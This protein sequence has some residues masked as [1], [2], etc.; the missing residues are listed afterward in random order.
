[1][2]AIP[3]S[4]AT[5]LLA[6]G[7]AGGEVPTKV[8]AVA[9]VM[10]RT[11]GMVQVANA[12][13]YAAKAVAS[14]VEEDEP[15]AGARLRDIS[16]AFATGVSTMIVGRALTTPAA[17][18]AH[19]KNRDALRFAASAANGA[20]ILSDNSSLLRGSAL[21]SPKVD[22]QLT[23]LAA[24]LP[25]VQ[26]VL[27]RYAPAVIAVQPELK[28]YDSDLLVRSLLDS[29]AAGAFNLTD[30]WASLAGLASAALWLRREIREEEAKVEQS[31]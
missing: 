15:E 22:K 3:S 4:A 31:K 17:L 12:L 29:A 1:M 30:G 26:H 7:L 11:D 20:L 16:K 8:T 28:P 23:I 25:A 13:R 24:A 2:A 18:A 6:N 21:L 9:R 5:V 14:A 27:S 19:A 10:Q